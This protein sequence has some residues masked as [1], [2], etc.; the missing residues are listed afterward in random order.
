M[1]IYAIIENGVVTNIVEWDGISNWSPPTGTTLAQI[2]DGT[3]TG[4]GSTYIDGV[5]G[6]PI[7]IPPPLI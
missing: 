3:S 6:S 1:A 4:I 7:N 2:P 5:F